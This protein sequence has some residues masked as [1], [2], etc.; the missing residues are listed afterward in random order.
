M[1]VGSPKSSLRDRKPI[2]N[3]KPIFGS[4]A[5]HNEMKPTQFE[6]IEE[7]R[8]GDRAR[9]LVPEQLNQVA[10]KAAALLMMFVVGVVANQ[11]AAVG[12]DTMLS[13]K[14]S[15]AA[16]ESCLSWYQWANPYNADAASENVVDRMMAEPDVNKF[17]KDFTDKLGQL[18]AVLIR[19]E[20]PPEIVLSLIHI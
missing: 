12:Q 7:R 20:A 11:S 3:R 8:W 1:G 5:L 19:D 18:P 6:R 9:R 15:S 14:L 13:S 4:E 2:I 16:P 10:L 17:C